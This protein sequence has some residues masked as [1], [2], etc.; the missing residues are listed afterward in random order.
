MIRI[1]HKARSVW[2]K[3][4]GFFFGRM[5]PVGLALLLSAVLLSHMHSEILTTCETVGTKGGDL[6]AEQCKRNSFSWKKMVETLASSKARNLSLLLIASI[7]WFFFYWRARIADQDAQ[8]AKQNAKTAEKVLTAEQITRAIEQLAHE[9]PS[10]R[11]GGILGLEQVALTQKEERVKIARI[12]VSFIR[13]RSR[14]NSE[15]TRNDLE[16]TGFTKLESR[17]TFSAYREQ[18]LDVEAAI[19]ALARVA[20]E[21]EKQRQFGAEYNKSK[22]YLCDLQNTDLRGLRLDKVDLSNFNFLRTDFS[23][24]WLAFTNFAKAGISLP[25][26]SPTEDEDI[27]KF[28]GADL[29]GA[30]F[31]STT[32]TGVNFSR[33]TLLYAIF[34]NA[35]LKNAS[36]NKCSIQGTHFENSKDL[37]QEQIDEADYS[38]SGDPPVLPE[39]LSFRKSDNHNQHDS[40]IS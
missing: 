23:G 15:E 4:R 31:S 3:F 10:V 12:L 9:K 27:T 18:R 8:T 35:R 25:S 39:G 6:V 16:K 24:A 20:S 17:E 13:T 7:G 22:R 33:S 21:L 19:P 26:A 36:F 32:L 40:D 28:I 11:L 34:N 5:L 1:I 2:I 38:D 14:K 30:D 37:T 29:L